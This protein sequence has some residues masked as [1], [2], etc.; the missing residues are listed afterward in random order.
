MLIHYLLNKDTDLVPEEAVAIVFYSKYSMC[1]AKNSNDTKHTRHIARIIHFVRNGE[2]C[3]MQNINWSEGGMQ[4]VD[5]DTKN[6]GEHDLTPIIKY[7]LVR[8]DN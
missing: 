2:K 3:E 6:F 5:I 4:L 8:L 1:M 7:I